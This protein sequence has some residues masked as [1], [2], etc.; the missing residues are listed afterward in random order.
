MTSLIKVG[1]VTATRLIL[2]L[3]KSTSP[4]EF[5]QWLQL[6]AEIVS[7]EDMLARVNNENENLRES[8]GYFFAYGILGML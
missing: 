3:W 8:W 4:P 7:Y 5:R 2:R 1:A 6:M